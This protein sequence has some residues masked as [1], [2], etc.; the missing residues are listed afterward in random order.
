MITLNVL[1]VG[2]VGIVSCSGEAIP[3]GTLSRLAC[4]KVLDELRPDQTVT[5]C[6]PLFIAGGTEE[7]NFARDFPTITVDGCE[8]QCARK[9]TEKLSGKPGKSLLIPEILSRHGIA[10]PV[11]LRNLRPEEKATAQVV[12]EEIARAVDEILKK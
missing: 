2:K 1:K 9:S 11:N 5:I 10:K 12:A 6:L 7:R 3:E 8:K 4:R